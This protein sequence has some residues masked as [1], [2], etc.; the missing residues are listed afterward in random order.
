M[1]NQDSPSGIRL[2]RAHEEILAPNDLDAN[3][4]R[5]SLGQLSSRDTD[6]ADLFFETT[7]RE[8]WKLE[9]GKVSSGTFSIMQGV[10]ARA[11]AGE[12]TAF[13]YSSDMRPRALGSVVGAV[14]S[15][16]SHGGGSHGIDGN[17]RFNGDSSRHDLYSTQSPGLG[18]D[19]ADKIR[20]LQKIDERARSVDPRIVR[21]SA[22]L[23]IVNS[24]VL[25]CATD[26][27]CAA[28]VRPFVKVVLYVL[29]QNGQRRASGGAGKG[30]RISLGQID[31]EA[32]GKLVQRSTDIALGNLDSRP[33]PAGVMSVVLG[34][35]FPGILLHEA[36]GHGLEGDAHRKRS[37][38]FVNHMGDA[39]AAPGVTVIDD[40]SV[41]RHAGS[42][43]IDDEG[44]PGERNVL[45]ENG[46][47][48]GLMQDKTNA[49][50]MKW[51]TTG[52]ARR[53]SYAHLPMPRMTNTF[54]QEGSYDPKE[55]IASVKN[56]IYATEFGG[57]T[58]DITSGQF[59]FAA[60]QAFR[61][62]NGKLTEPLEGATL[63]GV[64]HEALKHISMIG[65]DLALGEGICGKD[66]QSVD[67]GVGQPTVRID[68]MVVG[69]GA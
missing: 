34:P 31:D 28:D 18:M 25:V 53:Q 63:I 61:I 10:G 17:I 56:G 15:I 22:V 68:N 50:L 29:A 27:T 16:A 69:G 4:L 32:I 33:A 40:G 44:T 20:L 59:N 39:I 36:V 1:S 43:N 62:E 8:E 67:V 45:I 42:L 54:L 51:K 35:G 57:G 3:L 24:T 66:N 55:I 12:Q 41:E 2:A 11:I 48:V 23:N 38:V 52:N 7:S 65:N 30:G 46:K 64:G 9:D 37:S 49:R 13:A 26:G 6:Y 58:V 60:V 19:A 47:L 5:S 21:V 14:R